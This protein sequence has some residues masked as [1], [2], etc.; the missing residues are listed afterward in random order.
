MPSEPIWLPLENVVALN[1]RL[2]GITGEPHFLR[3]VGLL[4]SAINR[5]RNRWHY[6]ETDMVLLSASL[7]FGIARNHPFE[8][9]NKRTA[10][11]ASVIFLGANGYDF[12]AP[13]SDILGEF[14]LRTV[15]GTMA[16]VTFL[17]AY[18]KCI[19]PR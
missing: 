6:G 16:E 15:T 13:D 10:F 14:I 8:Q 17:K 5:P 12:V 1:K 19:I 2:V 4:D 11:A 9:G 3:D 18:R 7:L